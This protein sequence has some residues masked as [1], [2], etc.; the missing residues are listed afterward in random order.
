MPLRI[1]M[2]S[3][4]YPPL[5][6]GVGVACGEVLGE[7][8][9]CPGVCIDLVTSGPGPAQERIQFS[10]QIEIHKLPIGKKKFRQ[11]WR[12]REL[13]RWTWSALRYADD[14][15]RQ[16]RYDL[17]HC[18]GGWPSGIIGYRLRRR[19]PYVVA[20]R[21]SDVPGY[22]QRLWLFDPLVF[23]HVSRRVWRDAARL[24]ALSDALRRLAWGT[25]PG[26]AID[27]LPNGVDA[28]RFAPGTARSPFSLLFVGRLIER[29]SVHHLIEAVAQ[30]SK[31]QAGVRLIVAGDGPERMRLQALAERRGLEAG[32]EFLGHL[33][34]DR[35]AEVYRDASVLVVPSETEALGNVVLEAMA[36]GLAVITTRTG[37]SELIDGNGQVIEAPSPA[38][39]CA[40][41]ERYLS[42][43]ELLAEHQQVSRRR[44]QAM[45][46][47]AVAQD[48]LSIW[49]EVTREAPEPGHGSL[50]PRPAGFP[51]PAGG[52]ERRLKLRSVAQDSSGFDQP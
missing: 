50:A 6:G 24:L 8:S 46:W 31:G 4:E 1:L 7:L 16:R 40:A 3:Y 17:C 23:R 42:D 22:S 45:S 11:Y 9:R 36:S 43:P 52:T 41:V 14:L 28:V 2:I 47:Q 19:F 5:G 34:K 38:S 15:V 35:L 37:A 12:A 39:I 26:V 13:L 18:W 20:L 30:L 48:L 51:S 29:K 21:G 33:P 10:Q 44:A 49:S 32:V 25:L 27:I